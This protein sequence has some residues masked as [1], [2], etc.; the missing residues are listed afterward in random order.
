M[1]SMFPPLKRIKY[2]Q[3]S[4]INTAIP[5]STGGIRRLIKKLRFM[6]SND[7]AKTKTKQKAQQQTPPKVSSASPDFNKN[8]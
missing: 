4:T 1:R 6:F 2:A 7:F 5:W 3:S 8:Y